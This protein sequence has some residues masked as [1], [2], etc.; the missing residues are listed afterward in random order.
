MSIF[1]QMRLSALALTSL[2][3]LLLPLHWAVAAT[4]V[5]DEQQQRH[6][7]WLKTTFA[8]QHHAL[9]P[10]VAVADM[11]FACD[12]HR[13][14]ATNY[15]LDELVTKM[16]KEVL[17]QKLLSCLDG[18]TLQSDRAI[19]FGLLGCFQDQFAGLAAEQQTKKM[20]LV[21]RSIKTLSREQ[22]QQSLN[23]CV[24]TQAIRYLR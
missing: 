15:Q 9:I 12:Q 8:E 19:N 11:F 18:E 13:I 6:E 24:T 22:R 23:N 7:L 5:T 1:Q 21:R 4:E 16:D 10:V 3:G 17:A 14:A 2:I 20:T